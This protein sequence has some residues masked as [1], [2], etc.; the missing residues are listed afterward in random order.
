MR[1]PGPHRSQTTLGSLHRERDRPVSTLTPQLLL[2]AYTQ[3]IFPMDVEGEIA[4][5][6]PDPRAILP[7]D[8]FRAS[9]TLRQTCRSGRFEIRVDAAF[10]DVIRLC[11][12]RDEETWISDEIVHTYE[13]LHRCGMAHSV[14]AWQDKRLAGGLYGVVVGGAFF[15]ESMFY[16]ARDASKAALAALVERLQQRRFA[17]LDVQWM[18]EHLRRFGAVEISREEYLKRL[19]AAVRLRREFCDPP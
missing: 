13:E 9:K 4:W 12:D 18:T 15:G 14:E 3:G 16:R 7:L 1:F 2:A 6:S 11:A 19:A 5:F 10:S 17:L 8:G